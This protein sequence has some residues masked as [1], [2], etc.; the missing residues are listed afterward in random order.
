MNYVMMINEIY[1][2]IGIWCNEKM[3]KW[4]ENLDIITL[5]K[6]DCRW[7]QKFKCMLAKTFLYVGE[8][9]NIQFHTYSPTSRTVILGALGAACWWKFFNTIHFSTTLEQPKTDSFIPRLLIFTNSLSDSFSKLLWFLRFLII[10]W[11]FRNSWNNFWVW[12]IC[13]G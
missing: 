10:L 3:A 7:R 12:A 9:T 6:K 2:V 4:N 13:I 11:F 5:V 1:D 8:N